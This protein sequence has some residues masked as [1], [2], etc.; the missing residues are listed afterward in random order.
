MAKS[1]VYIAD[2]C[3]HQVAKLSHPSEILARATKLTDKSKEDAIDTSVTSL[4]SVNLLLTDVCHQRFFDKF[5]GDRR[6]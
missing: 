4:K 3:L 2:L 1:R 6:L 5:A